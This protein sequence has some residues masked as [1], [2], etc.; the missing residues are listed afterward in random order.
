MMPDEYKPGNQ[1]DYVDLPM[2]IP[3]VH[4]TKNKV[5]LKK[6]SCN[7]D[8]LNG[9]FKGWIAEHFKFNIHMGWKFKTVVDEKKWRNDPKQKKK[10]HK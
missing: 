9:Y 10:D 4:H 1:N 8:G 2:E 3:S 5:V 6:N 7:V